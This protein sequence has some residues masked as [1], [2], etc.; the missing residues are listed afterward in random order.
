VKE[1][2]QKKQLELGGPPRV[3]YFNRTRFRFLSLVKLAD[4]ALGL[5][6][7]IALAQSSRTNFIGLRTDFKVFLGLNVSILVLTDIWC[8][9]LF[10]AIFLMLKKKNDVDEDSDSD[11]SIGYDKTPVTKRTPKGKGIIEES[12]VDDNDVEN[13]NDDDDEDDDEEVDEDDSENEDDEYEEENNEEYEDYAAGH[14]DVEIDKADY[15][16][17]YDQNEIIEDESSP[18]HQKSTKHSPALAGNKISSQFHSVRENFRRGLSKN[19][20]GSNTDDLSSPHT[21]NE[22]TS[23]Q[24]PQENVHVRI[25]TIGDE[26]FLV[27]SDSKQSAYIGKVD[28][29]ITNEPN[30]KSRSDYLSMD[31]NSSIRPEAYNNLYSAIS[32]ALSSEFNCKIVVK[33]DFTFDKLA[34]HLSNNGF[35]IVSSN[36]IEMVYECQ[37]FASGYKGHENLMFLANLKII[38]SSDKSSVM[39]CTSKSTKMRVNHLF[40]ARFSLGDLMTLTD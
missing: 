31:F 27:C 33:D 7:W 36:K 11:V 3:Y 24:Y 34:K 18:L 28:S 32:G 2:T 26:L 14:D 37:L 35:F 17:G 10:Y 40:I 8:P 38:L 1:Y 15:E 30:R 39:Q 4:V 6:L 13:V 22:K 19:A 25:Q 29:I 20:F 16:D 21:K 5:M 9:L 12:E 23:I